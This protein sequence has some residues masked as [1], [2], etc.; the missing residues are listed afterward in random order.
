MFYYELALGASTRSTSDSFTY[1]SDLEIAPGSFVLL[2]FK[3]KQVMGIIVKKV[4]KPAFE[5]KPID[6]VCP[7]SPLP[8]PHQKLLMILAETHP[9]S[10][11]ALAKLFLPPTTKTY[12]EKP[13]KQPAKAAPL[14]PLNA[15]QRRAFDTVM[16]TSGNSLLFGETGSGKTRIYLHL[17]AQILKERRSVLILA[18]EIGLSSFLYHQIMDHFPDALLYHSAQTK[19]QRQLIWQRAA[20]S[21]EPVIVVGP[22]SALTLPVHDIGLIIIDEAHDGSYK[23]DN[24]P[25]LR[26]HEVAVQLAR[27]SQARYVYATATP[28]TADYYYA[29][30]KGVPIIRITS[31]AVPSDSKKPF[32]IHIVSYDDKTEFSDGS[33]ISH[34]ALTSI[35]SAIKQ[36]RQA[37]VLLNK[38]GTAH[39]IHCQNCEWELRCPKCDRGLVYHRDTHRAH[40][41][42]CET[43]V[44]MPRNCPACQGDITL[45][46]PGT[47]AISDYLDHHIPG[48]HLARFDTDSESLN[49]IQSRLPELQSGLINCIVGTQMIAKG[50]DLPLLET[51]VVLYAEGS[52]GSDYI[53]EERAFQLLYQVVGRGV[54]GHR[55]TQIYLQ[56]HNQNH[57]TL[58]FATKRDTEGFLSHELGERKA[59]VYPPF[60]FM[61]VIHYKRKTSDGALK[62]GQDFIDKL[63][64]N[65]PDVRF[66]SPLANVYE[67][68]G[69]FYHWH[70]VVRSRHKE[71]LV[72]LARAAGSAWSF[73]LDPIGT[74]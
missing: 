28:N 68:Q 38:R 30:Q 73:D 35:K 7:L 40:C 29:S 9:Y 22:R 46:T 19:K 41:H 65:F 50:L 12:V 15:D 6:S 23:Q 70:I 63:Q 59:Y 53:A 71:A 37:M 27:L 5:T 56:T 74:P 47:K 25:Y 8:A 45:S 16:Q 72:R 49:T 34:S 52:S 60:T 58:A 69:P 13:R 48:I 26:S 21:T 66:D 1:H 24:S 64:P 42:T 67:R 62:A 2:S 44:T 4:T 18:P 32:D 14:P 33:L 17:A 51:I 36:G 11:T 61:S 43:K 3:D 10:S 31:Q 20:T 57:P 54:R 39:H 55:H